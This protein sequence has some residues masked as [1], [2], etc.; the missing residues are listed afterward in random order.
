MNDN[1]TLWHL[2]QHI[3]VLEMIILCCNMQE[4]NLGITTTIAT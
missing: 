3:G 4:D 1:S 2:V